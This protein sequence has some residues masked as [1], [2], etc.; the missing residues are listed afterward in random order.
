MTDVSCGAH[1]R[2]HLLSSMLHWH[3][4]IDCIVHHECMDDGENVQACKLMQDHCKGC[5]DGE[6]RGSEN[7]LASACAASVRFPQ[8]EMLSEPRA[9][10]AACTC[11]QEVLAC[12]LMHLHEED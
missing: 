1:T 10:S 5:E 8:A 3:G 6:I 12:L 7:D 4:C 9:F 2:A 11:Q